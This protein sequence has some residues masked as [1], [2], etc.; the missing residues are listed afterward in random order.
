MHM[1]ATAT[2]HKC[3]R[4]RAQRSRVAPAPSVRRAD[5]MLR[6]ARHRQ[7]ARRNTECHVKRISAENDSQTQWLAEQTPIRI[8]AHMA[9][10]NNRLRVAIP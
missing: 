8:D 4:Q 6:T 3:K 10:E 9:R 2:Q 7:D 5:G 1:E